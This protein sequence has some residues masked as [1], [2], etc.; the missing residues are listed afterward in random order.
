MDLLLVMFVLLVSAVECWTASYG[1][2]RDFSCLAIWRRGHQL[3]PR[4]RA[5]WLTT[6]W[7]CQFLAGRK[8]CTTR[9]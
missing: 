5:S 9:F 1:Q 7:D 3:L 6:S 4:S 2:Y 8:F